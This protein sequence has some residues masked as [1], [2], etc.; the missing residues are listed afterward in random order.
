MANNEMIV[1]NNFFVYG[2]TGERLS[3][4]RESDTYKSS[5]KKIRNLVLTELGNLK[6]A[7]QYVKK[8]IPVNNII[9]ILDTRYNFFIIV[10][11]THIYTLNKSNYEVLY[12]LEH[13]LSKAITRDINIKMF[14]DSLMICSNPPQVYEFDKDSGNI[15]KS[16]FIDLLKYPIIEKEDVKMDIYKVYEVKLSDKTELRVALLSTYINPKLESKDDGIY[17]YETGLKLERVYK[18]YKSS[19][20]SENISG[21]TKGMM[22]G[23]LYRFAKNEDEKSYILGNNNISFT[24][25]TEDSVYGSSYF[26]GINVKNISGDLVYGKLQTLKDNFTDIG[27][28]SDR[29]CIIKDNTFYFSRKDNFFDFRNGSEADDPF[30]FKPT[31]ISNQKPNILKMRIGNAVYVA[32]DKG[33]Y[34][35][36]YSKVLSATSYSVFIAGEV[37]STRECELIGDNFYYITPDQQLKCVQAVPNSFGYESY[38][39]FDAEKYDIRPNIILLT[40]INIDG[41]TILVATHSN[42]E[43]IYLYESLDYNS[44]RRTSLDIDASKELFG[45]REHFICDNAILEKSNKNYAEAE[46]FMNP[47]YISTQ[48]GGNYSNDYQSQIVR[49]FMKLLNEDRE[50]V[51]GVYLINMDKPLDDKGKDD[52]FSTYKYENAVNVGNGYGVKIL[53]KENDKVLEILG[54]DAKVKVAS[55]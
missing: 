25:S 29:L 34:V 12:S 40:K 15:G 18:Q 8:N 20:D 13:K 30:Y 2:E 9:E 44:F 28:I 3:G 14:E 6:F 54:I 43:L 33:V 53:S 46:L 11:T 16:D 47:P 10:T 35:I 26:T 27:V 7:K 5:A 51:K 23:V 4:I 22:F 42:K 52:M 49:A 31:P 39:T 24:G 45:Y 55:D 36:S 32:T 38:K 48:K 19:I 17:L 1:R 21:V 50:A 37:P 41:R